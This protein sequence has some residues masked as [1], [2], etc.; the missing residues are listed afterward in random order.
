MQ[1]V[2]NLAAEYGPCN[3]RVN[4]IAPGL[5]RTDFARALWEDEKLL[6]QRTATTPLRRIGAAD[7]IAGAAVFLAPRAGAFLTGE[8]IDVD[9]GGQID[10]KTND[11]ADGRRRGGRDRKSEG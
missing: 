7:E 10:R 1:L 5:V 11:R 9:G 3:V 6:K 2:R 4:C 8:T